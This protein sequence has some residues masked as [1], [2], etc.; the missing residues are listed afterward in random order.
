MN[1][2][3]MLPAVCGSFLLLALT[4]PL[5]AA[6]EKAD[7]SQPMTL[8]ADRVSIDDAHKIGTYDGSVVLIQGTMRISAEHL[9]VKQNDSGVEWAHATGTPVHFRQRMDAKNGPPVWAEGSALRADYD[10]PH[11]HL[12]LFGQAWIKHGGDEVRG[13]HIV[14]NTVSGDFQVQGT[15]GHNGTA[16]G[17]VHAV[18]Q[19][20]VKP[21]AQ[22]P[23][24]SSQ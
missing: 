4:W 16:S 15:A 3:R 9:V 7:A 6:A 22:A 11:Q 5:P 2:P 17:Q 14:Y 19:P 24:G 21:G 13:A 20:R 12:E 1:L 10:A 18:I 23:A 8:D